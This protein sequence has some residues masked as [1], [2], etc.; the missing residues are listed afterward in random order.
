M[1]TASCVLDA[2][3]SGTDVRIYDIVFGAGG[4]GTDN[5]TGLVPHGL[6]FT[7][8]FY[9]FYAT[10]APA[11]YADLAVATV[12]ATTFSVTQA[13]AVDGSLRLTIGRIPNPQNER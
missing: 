5:T 9:S 8:N 7:P 2:A 6:P 13:N 3:S 4:A 12:S 1:T 10:V 11:T